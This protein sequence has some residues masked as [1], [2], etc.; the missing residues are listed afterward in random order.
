MVRLA[1]GG[2]R[3]LKGGWFTANGSD[4]LFE[5]LGLHGD[6]FLKRANDTGWVYWGEDTSWAAG[7]VTAVVFSP[8]S[9]EA[10]HEKRR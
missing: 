6:Q 1:A 10:A 8:G 5:S 4:Y 9:G 2:K 7:S 3:Y